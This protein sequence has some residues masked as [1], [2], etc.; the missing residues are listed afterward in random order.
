MPLPPGSGR[1][2]YLATIDQVVVPAFRNFMPEVIFIASGFD[3]GVYDPLGRMMVTSSTFRVMTQAMVNLAAEL[4]GNRMGLSHEGGYSE[5][6]VPFCGLAVM[7][8]LSGLNTGV[9]DPFTMNVDH[10]GGHELYSHQNEVIQSAAKLASAV[11][12]P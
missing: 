2:A 1:E 4:C 12:G 8:A 11:S 10:V 3:G 9:E 5:G 7:E 6:Y